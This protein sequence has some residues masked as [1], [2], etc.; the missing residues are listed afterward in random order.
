MVPSRCR[1]TL[2]IM[3][4]TVPGVA[5]ARLSRGTSGRAT[6]SSGRAGD[7]PLASKGKFQ[8]ELVDG[9]ASMIVPL[10]RAR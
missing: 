3:V 8:L 1:G 7:A 5:L 9:R 10:K 2:G 4:M 6:T